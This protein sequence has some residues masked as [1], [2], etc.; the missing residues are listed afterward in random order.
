MQVASGPIRYDERKQASFTAGQET[1][2]LSNSYSDTKIESTVRYLGIEVDDALAIAEQVDCLNSLGRAGRPL[3]TGFVRITGQ[4]AELPQQN[5]L[6]DCQVLFC[7][8]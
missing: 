1:Y 7:D 5:D 4:E 6:E 8:Q 3:P 2:V